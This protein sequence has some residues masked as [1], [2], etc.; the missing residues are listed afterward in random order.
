[1]AEPDQI[2]ALAHH[3]ESLGFYAVEF[4]DHIVIP[5]GMKS[6]YPYSETGDPPGWEDWLEQLTALS[7][8]AGKTTT[9]RL[10]TSVMVLPYRHPLLA[11]KML[12][13]LDVLSKGRLI[14]GVGAGWMKEEFEALG[15]PPFEER[16]SVSEEYVL[17][18][19]EVWTS[20]RPSFQGKYFSFNGIKFL[21]KPVQKPHPQIWVG[22]EGDA[23]LRRAAR[24][25]DARYPIRGNPR[26]PLKTLEQL[27]YA[28]DRLHQ[29]ARVAGRN[30]SEIQIGLVSPQFRLDGRTTDEL[31]MGSV[32]KVSSDVRSCQKLGVS[33]LS[34]DL[35]DSDLNRTISRM[36]EFAAQLITRQI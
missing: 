34:F 36:D 25:G 32:D 27:K 18:F 12:A 3:A 6:R 29:H 22:G 30:P 2:A 17:I 20:E 31:F 7:F 23:A 24:F 10:I 21:P 13:S 15:L 11:A 14:V 28:I 8:L 16:G 1:M 9:I 26:Y 5:E 33:Y 19:K 4:G 35:L